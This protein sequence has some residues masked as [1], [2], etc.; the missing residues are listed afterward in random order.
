MIS[1]VIRRKVEQKFGSS[2]KY[3]SDCQRLAEAIEKACH[4]KLSA[5]TIKRL[6]SLTKDKSQPRPYTLDVIAN[7]LG[8]PDYDGLI[9]DIVDTKTKV[10]KIE[11]I[12]T[13]KLKAGIALR[14]KF[15]H[16]AKV[17][18]TYLGKGKYRVTESEKVDL[19][20]DDV[21]EIALI[22]LDMPVLINRLIRDEINYTGFVVG[23]ITGATEIIKLQ[24]L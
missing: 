8:Y 5:T 19:L 11:L 12:E 7:Y 13:R 22:K 17:D 24:E 6:F 15:G 3:P 16:V 2:I 9:N 21:V 4:C 14:I 20:K 18:L 10:A 23:K 1:K